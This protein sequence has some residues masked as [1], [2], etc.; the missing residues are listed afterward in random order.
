M[1]AFYFGWQNSC[2]VLFQEGGKGL[3]AWPP[4]D[5]IR[6]FF[7]QPIGLRVFAVKLVGLAGFIVKL[8]TSCLIAGVL[9]L[10]PLRTPAA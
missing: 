4:S 6:I 8:E 10:E 9:G 2:R 5:S 3:Q 7:E 1:H